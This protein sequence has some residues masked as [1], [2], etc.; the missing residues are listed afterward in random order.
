[1]KGQAN[2]SAVLLAAGL[3]FVDPTEIEKEILLGGV[4]PV[5]EREDAPVEIG[6]EKTGSSRRAGEQRGPVKDQARERAAGC[7]GRRRFGRADDAGT[8]PERALGQ[9]V[10]FRRAGGKGNQG[11]RQQGGH[12]P[13]GQRETGNLRLQRTLGWATGRIQKHG[14]DTPCK[15]PY[16]RT[17][18]CRTGPCH[19]MALW[20]T[21]A[22]RER[23]A[24]HDESFAIFS[25]RRHALA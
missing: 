19:G 12:R 8:C 24:E 15:I 21:G 10:G 13:S 9:A 14:L 17:V 6:D 16:Y 4:G 11:K 23:G 18:C 22:R 2:D 3:G 5:L 7:V 20:P 25:P 1:M